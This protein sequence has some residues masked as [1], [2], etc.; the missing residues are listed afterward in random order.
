MYRVL[1]SRKAQKDRAELERSGLKDKVEQ[2]LEELSKD[3]FSVP[4]KKL[5]GEAAGLYS[6]RLNITDR[7]VFEV[8]ESSD[9]RYEGIVRVIR[10]R[11]RYKG[12]APVFLL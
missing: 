4:S 3:P 11:T 7:V 12:I 8:K 6:R 10:M 5:K 2:M 1:L 9:P